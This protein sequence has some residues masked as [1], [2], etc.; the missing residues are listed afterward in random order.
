MSYNPYDALPQVPSFTVT[1]DD[2]ADG[3]RFGNDQVSGVFG[4]G[5]KD[6]SPQLSWSGFPAETKSF[7]VTVFDP[8]AP[9]ASGFW[10]WA[11]ADLPASVTSLPAGAGSQG[12]ELPDGV[13][14]LRNDGGFAGYVGA[15]PPPGH[16]PHRYFIVVHAVDVDS[17]D[18]PADASPAFL[19]FNLFS[20][21]LA[22]ATLVATYEQN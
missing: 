15:A 8:D 1:S 10:H 14:Q 12:G 16:G 18:I 22:R 2:V 6:V 13:V 21:T 5:G 20:H 11:V 7:A 17:L 19:G 4:A 9:T 3:Q